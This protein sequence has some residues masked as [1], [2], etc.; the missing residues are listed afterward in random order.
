[1]DP[2]SVPP[3]VYGDII[4][5]VMDAVRCTIAHPTARA[6]IDYLHTLG[7]MFGSVL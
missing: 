6:Y 4:L 7:F 3:S 5:S 2:V 1:M